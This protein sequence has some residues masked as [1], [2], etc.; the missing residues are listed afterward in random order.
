MYVNFRLADH[1]LRQFRVDTEPSNA[2]AFYSI[3][4]A[5][6]GLKKKKEKKKIYHST[7]LQSPCISI[8][9]ITNAGFVDVLIITFNP[10]FHDNRLSCK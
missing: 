6:L 9:V 4:L 1:S 10:V 2:K 7:S 3:S 5:N 8:S